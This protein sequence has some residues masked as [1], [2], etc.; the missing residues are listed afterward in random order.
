MRV[1]GMQV[2]GCIDQAGTSMP[3]RRRQR[4]DCF[5]K[6]GNS[7]FSNSRLIS[8]PDREK[9]GHQEVID[10]F[11]GG[12]WEVCSGSAWDNRFP[13]IAVPGA[14]VEFAITREMK[15]TSYQQNACRPA[16]VDKEPEGGHDRSEGG[17]RLIGG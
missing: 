12:G 16:V 4:E 11:Q 17:V 14:T 10:P 8:I 7:P 5:L 3:Q 9:K 2:E 13:A 1:S 6:G 15:R